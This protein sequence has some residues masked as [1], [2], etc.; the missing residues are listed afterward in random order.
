LREQGDRPSYPALF[1]SILLEEFQ[2]VSAR[3]AEEGVPREATERGALGHLSPALG[4]LGAKLE[5]IPLLPLSLRESTRT[6]REVLSSEFWVL[7]CL[8]QY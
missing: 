2:K 1:F 5:G 7:S 8:A 6:F 4:G 3:T